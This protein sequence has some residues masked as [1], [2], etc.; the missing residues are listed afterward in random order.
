M[1]NAEMLANHLTLEDIELRLRLLDHVIKAAQADGDERWK[2]TARPQAE[3]LNEARGILIKRQR[4][5]QGQTQ[6]DPVV[7]AANIGNTKGIGNGAG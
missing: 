6:P 5:A 1:N 7:I 2:T 3:L 4:A